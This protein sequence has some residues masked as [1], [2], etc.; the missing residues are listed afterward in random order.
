MMM[1]Y[2]KNAIFGDEDEDPHNSTKEG[3]DI[4]KPRSSTQELKRPG[5]S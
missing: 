5:S 1:S 3:G 2:F 4:K